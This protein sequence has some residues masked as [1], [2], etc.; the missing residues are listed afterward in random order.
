MQVSQLLGLDP[1]IH[2]SGSVYKCRLRVDFK[3]I[4]EMFFDSFFIGGST[5]GTNR[6]RRIFLTDARYEL[7]IGYAH[8]FLGYGYDITIYDI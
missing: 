3:G 8:L 7:E 2:L 4:M 1:A 5:S 6:K